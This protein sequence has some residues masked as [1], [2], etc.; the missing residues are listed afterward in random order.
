[1]DD[2]RDLRW[3]PLK[4]KFIDYPNAQ[5]MMLGEAQG[6]LGKGDKTEEKAPEQEDAGEELEHL[7]GEDEIRAEA[8]NGKLTLVA[9]LWSDLAGVYPTLLPG[10]FFFLSGSV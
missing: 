3:A 5:F 2:F 6:H 4:P 9:Q 8:L 10:T 1:M 7:E